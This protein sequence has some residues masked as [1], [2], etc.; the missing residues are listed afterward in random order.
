MPQFYFVLSLLGGRF[1]SL[2][3]AGN[4]FWQS[5]KMMHDE[6]TST[7]EAGKNLGDFY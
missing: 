2:V 3:L 6:L 5:R 4:Y 1:W 7:G